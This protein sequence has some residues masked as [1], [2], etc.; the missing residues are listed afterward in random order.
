MGKNEHNSSEKFTRLLEK[1]G[2]SEGPR[3]TYIEFN[4]AQH[5]AKAG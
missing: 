2:Q 4:I 3:P 5:F 1:K